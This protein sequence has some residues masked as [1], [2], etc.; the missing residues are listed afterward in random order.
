M[1]E[2]RIYTVQPLQIKTDIILDT[3]AA[4]HVV[5]VLRLRVGDSL[6]LF[7][8]NGYEYSGELTEIHQKHTVVRVSSMSAKPSQVSLNIHL[9][10]GIS[11]GERMDLALQKAVELGVTRL[12]PL[13]ARRSV[14]QLRGERLERRHEHWQQIVIAACE[15]SGR[16]YLPQ[17]DLPQPLDMALTTTTED[18][19]LML[20]HLGTTTL[21]G[22]SQPTSGVALLVGPE[23]GLDTEELSYA[24][25]LGFI[26]LRLGPRILRTET[27]PLAALA[28]IQCLWGDLR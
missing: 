14:V 2:R 3:R 15:Q 24:Q 21:G 6:C 9:I 16:C 11:R 20:H 22:I 25:R 7:N 23:G 28:A 27:A 10:I 12:S 8:G 26:P 1:R 19:R 17:L 18:M 5:G 13:L 4:H